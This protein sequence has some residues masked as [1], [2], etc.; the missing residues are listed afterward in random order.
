MT[1]SLPLR[2]RA[3][4][5]SLRVADCL[6]WYLQ[7]E[8]AAHV[9]LHQLQPGAQHISRTAHGIRDHVR[10]RNEIHP[11][12]LGEGVG[13]DGIG[14]HF[15]VGDRLQQLRV[16]QLEVDPGRRQQIPQPVPTPGRLD[17]RLVG[18]GKLSEV[19]QQRRPLDSPS[20]GA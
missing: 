5:L 9:S 12:Q 2:R 7:R 15:G 8:G 1:Q 14:L 4:R 17:D 16:G 19:L 11:Q 3:A 18:T 13:I 20:Q 10:V 6:M